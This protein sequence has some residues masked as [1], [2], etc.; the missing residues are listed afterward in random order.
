MVYVIIPN[1]DFENSKIILSPV[2][3]E[4]ATYAST[5]NGNIYVPLG[6]N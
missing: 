5:E 4:M 1:S 3:Q 2:N 6:Q